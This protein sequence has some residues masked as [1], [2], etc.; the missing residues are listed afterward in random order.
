MNVLNQI[1]LLLQ[2]YPNL[3][4][5]NLTTSE[6]YRYIHALYYQML[7]SLKYITYKFY[8]AY[9]SLAKKT[10]KRKKSG[11]VETYYWIFVLQENEF[12]HV[13]YQYHLL[14]RAAINSIVK[15]G[16]YIWLII[17]IGTVVNSDSQMATRVIISYEA[18]SHAMH[19]RNCRR[20]QMEKVTIEHE[21]NKLRRR[22]NRV[23]FIVQSSLELA[24]AL[25]V[26]EKA[27]ANGFDGKKE[28]YSLFLRD[29]LSTEERPLQIPVPAKGAFTQFVNVTYDQSRNKTS[30]TGFSIDVFQAAFLPFDGSYDEMVEQEHNKEAKPVVL[31]QRTK[32]KMGHR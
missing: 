4:N 8:Y 10:R 1:R 6:D 23:F 13:T 9:V 31:L 12:W 5:A 3:A 25:L 14:L 16:C 22:S 11:Q 21:F 20:I 26:F 15:G 17:S 18:S 28:V 32:K 24:N 7:L 29:G 2:A 30:I 27:K 19:C